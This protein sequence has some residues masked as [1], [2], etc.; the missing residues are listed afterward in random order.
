MGAQRIEALANATARRLFG[1]GARFNGGVARA[2][3]FGCGVFE[4]SRH[5]DGG[6]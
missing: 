5:D 6:R 4:L 3:G 2:G 1:N